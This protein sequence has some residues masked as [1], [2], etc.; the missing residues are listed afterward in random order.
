MAT[1]KR[2]S[3]AFVQSANITIAASLTAPVYMTPRPPKPPPGHDKPGCIDVSKAPQWRIAD[4]RWNYIDA[5]AG[6]RIQFGFDLTNLANGVTKF[7][8]LDIPN[9]RNGKPREDEWISNINVDG[10][11]EYWRVYDIKVRLSFSY[12]LQSLFLPGGS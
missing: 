9:L 6:D 12:R 2:G 1:I 4:L 8:K 7:V 10:W 5:F 11:G 3:D